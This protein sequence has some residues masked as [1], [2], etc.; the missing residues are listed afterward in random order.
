MVDHQKKYDNNNGDNHTKLCL[1]RG[2]FLLHFMGAHQQEAPVHQQQEQLPLL[3]SPPS[4]THHR[5]SLVPSINKKDVFS[6]F[7]K[8]ADV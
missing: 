8:S 3:A 6:L 2:G 5:C 1:F 4:P 7:Q